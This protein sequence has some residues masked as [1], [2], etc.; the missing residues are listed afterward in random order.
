MPLNNKTY[1]YKESDYFTIKLTKT[2]SSDGKTPLEAMILDNLIHSYVSLDNP[3]HIEY[4][5]KRI[6]ADVLKWK[7]KKD[8]DFKSLT[9]GGGGYT[10]PRYMEVYYPNAHIDV[11]EIDPEV[12]NIV[13]KNLGLPKTTRIRSF[14]EDGRW[15]VMNCMTSFLPTPTMTF[16]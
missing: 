16:P 5:H 7:F 4:E 9:I 6:Y 15:Y 2:T 10:F 12:T 1:L 11:V 14:N 3:L 8:L 13:Y